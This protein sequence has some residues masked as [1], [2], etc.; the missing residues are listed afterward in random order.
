MK[1]NLLLLFHQK[2]LYQSSD[3][4]DDLQIVNPISNELSMMRNSLY[5]NLLDAVS[6][7]YAKGFEAFSLFEIGDV[8]KA[9]MVV[10]INK[11]Q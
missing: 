7:N 4:N 9:P 2:K 11:G 1:L 8:F 3:F 5:P 6:K 10:L